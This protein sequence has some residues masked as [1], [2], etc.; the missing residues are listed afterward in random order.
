[1]AVKEPAAGSIVA[2]SIAMIEAAERWTPASPLSTDRNG[3]RA[4]E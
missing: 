1:V 3:D 4:H 2:R